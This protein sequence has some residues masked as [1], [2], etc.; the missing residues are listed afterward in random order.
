[1]NHLKKKKNETKDKR[2]TYQS[3]FLWLKF[4]TVDFSNNPNYPRVAKVRHQKNNLNFPCHTFVFLN[5]EKS[6]EHKN[7]ISKI[8]LKSQ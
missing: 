8:S 5:G 4:K 3:D 6:L 2:K 7:R 1:M